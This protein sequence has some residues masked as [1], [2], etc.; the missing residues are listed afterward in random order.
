MIEADKT[1][2]ARNAVLARHDKEQQK[3][4][5]RINELERQCA[6]LG[7]RR[8]ESEEAYDELQKILAANLEHSEQLKAENA[9][10]AQESEQ[11]ALQSVNSQLPSTRSS[12]ISRA[13]TRTS[14][15]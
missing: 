14:P 8:K 1:I 3:L 15:R 10:R 7:A 6:E 4:A 12:A 2:N 11:A 13:A 9:I 5:D